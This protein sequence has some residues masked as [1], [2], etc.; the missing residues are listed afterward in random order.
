[1][2]T[3]RSSDL[4][5]VQ[6]LRRLAARR[7]RSE[8]AHAVMRAWLR[9]RSPERGRLLDTMCRFGY[10]FMGLASLSVSGLTTI[11][12]GNAVY[13]RRAVHQREGQIVRRG[14][15]GRLHLRG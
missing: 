7:A 6:P 14:V 12:G 15:P 11:G 3:R 10:K 1:F 2:P 4:L 9:R 13:H 8:A 5:R